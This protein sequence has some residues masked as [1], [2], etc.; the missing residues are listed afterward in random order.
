MP[1]PNSYRIVVNTIECR[2]TSSDYRATSSD[3]QD[4]TPF[5]TFDYEDPLLFTGVLRAVA[6]GN[7]DELK[8]LISKGRSP[9]INDNNG[10][11]P[12]HVAVIRNHAYRLSIEKHNEQVKNNRYVLSKIINCIKFC[13]AFELALRGHDEQKDSLNPGIFRGLINFS[14]E[15]DLA[16][17]DHLQQPTVFKGTSKDIQNDL[18]E[19][20]LSVCQANIKKEIASSNF[21]SVMSDETSD[22]SNI[23]QMVIVY[24]YT[25]PNGTPVERFWTFIKP[26]DHDAVAL[27]GCI[28][29]SLNPDQLISQSYDGASVM[30]GA[31]GGA[32]VRIFFADL[33]D[34]TN[35]FSNSPQRVAILDEVVGNRVPRAAL[36]TSATRWNFKIRTVN[37]VYENKESLLE[38]MEKIQSTSRQSDTIRKAGAL[39]RLLHDRKFVFWLTVF[40]RVMPH[41]DI[42]YSQLQKRAT[43]SVTVKRNITEFEKN[44]QKERDNIHTIR[45]I[46]LAD[47]DESQA[48]KRRKMDERNSYV[49]TTVQAKEVCDTIIA[50]IKKRPEIVD[51]L[52]SLE[53]T[54]VNSRNFSGE[55]PLFHAVKREDLH[56]LEKLIEANGNVNQPNHCE[57]T[58]LHLS[59]LVNNP[60][61]ARVLIQ[62]GANLN[63]QDYNDETPLYYAVCSS[64]IEI[65]CMLLYFNADANI[66]C[67]CGITPFMN[68][69]LLDR[70]EIQE[71]LLDY[72][73]DFNKT[74]KEGISVLNLAFEHTC[75]YVETIINR[76]ADVNSNVIQVCLRFPNVDKFRIIWKKIEYLEIQFSYTSYLHMLVTYLNKSDLYQY[77]RVIID[78]DNLEPFFKGFELDSL[79]RKII[80]SSDKDNWFNIINELVILYLSHGY[81]LTH[82]VIG[83][84]Y[85]LFGYNELFYICLHMDIAVPFLSFHEL[86]SSRLDNFLCHPEMRVECF[87]QLIFMSYHHHQELHAQY[88]RI[89]NKE[90]LPHLRIGCPRIPTEFTAHPVPSLLELARNTARDGLVEK[91]KLFEPKQYYFFIDNMPIPKVIKHYLTF[92]KPI[93]SIKME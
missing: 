57:I 39:L 80:D 66:E 7:L 32:N 56:L 16:L 62:N 90:I 63:A 46:E 93:Y 27:A 77:L 25:L 67:G 43:D 65:V 22:I 30:S 21:V 72:V 59:V 69:I 20:M 75:P 91:F 2:V 6:A 71:I 52:L 15:L 14:A 13:G 53:E 24:R 47:I 40:H 54:V 23:F 86:D 19:C 17:R 70:L 5:P 26:N 10:N 3:C 81:I 87:K 29:E 79:C 36:G 74:T 78:S 83:P 8:T 88:V 34:I 49:S 48:R 38:C 73:D 37:T 92:R 51:Y 31:H 18:L 64:C 82:K 45:E 35:F 28:E 76:G 68:S 61:I 60:E 89:L 50:E 9:N 42:L 58:P 4:G 84:L 55:T 44:I 41:V 11:T 33:S 85:N 1:R 12:L